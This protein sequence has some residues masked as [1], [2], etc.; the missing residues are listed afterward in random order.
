MIIGVLSDTHDCNHNLI[1]QAV[2][3]LIKRGAEILV[4]C[5]D[6]EPQHLD[7]ELF[8]GLP[9]I[10]ATTKEQ[11]FD[12]QY[13]FPPSGWCFTR[14]GSIMN[15]IV[16]LNG[17]KMYVGHER[18][19]EALTD[20]LKVTNFLHQLN[21]VCDG[22]R[23]VF[24]GHIHYQ[25]LIQRSGILWINPGAIVGNGDRGHAFALVD[26]DRKE[27]VLTRIMP[28]AVECQPT[29]VGIV[30]DTGNVTQRQP[31]FWK[32]LAQEFYR[33]NATTIILA[34]NHWAG[35]IGC[36]AFKDFTV[37]YFLL[38]D[39]VLPDTVPANWHL[40]PRDKPVVNV[41]GH[42]FLI[43][44]GWGVKVSEISEYEALKAAKQMMLEYHQIDFVVCGLSRGALFEE[45]EDIT[46]LNPG[47]ARTSHNFV[48]ICLPRREITFSRIH[49]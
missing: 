48:T 15:R 4:H 33:R 19:F 16:S 40:I 47:D 42:R 45:G 1:T 25:F 11:F 21:Q 7:A 26:T 35:D 29:T 38:P 2:E 34:G 36:E 17:L 6:I 10:C 41:C 24:S 49:Y 23:L 5:G 27:T 31:D 20:P 30:V 14:P 28:T 37:Y 39:Q 46:I 3:D 18:T 32:Q 44:Y 12:P 9:V 22:V 13:V 43:D 8:G